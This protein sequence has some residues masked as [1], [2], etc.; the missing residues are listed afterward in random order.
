MKA[1]ATFTIQALKEVDSSDVNSMLWTAGLEIEEE[2]KREVDNQGLVDTS[3]F[4]NTIHTI[5]PMGNKVE[6]SDGVN[7]GI[8]LEYETRPH[9]ITPKVKKALYWKG[10]EHP[11]KS[12]MH[13]GTKAYRPFTTGLIKSQMKVLEVFRDYVK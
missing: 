7:Y 12:V 10:A 2:I 13:P 8:H 4:R 5:P 9:K 11:V 1:T 6:V 3:L